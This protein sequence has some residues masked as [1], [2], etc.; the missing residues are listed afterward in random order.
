M[1]Y[2]R[3]GERR[4]LLTLKNLEYTRNEQGQKRTPLFCLFLKHYA[5]TAPLHR[6]KINNVWQKT[7]M[8]GRPCRSRQKTK[9]ERSRHVH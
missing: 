7:K 2:L 4:A 5:R 9:Q 1:I 8:R 3:R 6:I